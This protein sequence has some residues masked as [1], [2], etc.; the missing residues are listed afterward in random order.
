MYYAFDVIPHG[1]SFKIIDVQ[2]TTGAG[3]HEMRT[4]YGRPEAR[5]RTKRYVA[6]LTE[7]AKGKII[8]Y[9]HP[10]PTAYVIHGMTKEASELYKGNRH[11]KPL[12]HWRRDAAA[13]YRRREKKDENGFNWSRQE[14]RI[15]HQAALDLGADIAFGQQIWQD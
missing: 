9:G 11:W 15:L 6:K 10:S 4:A 3:I 1:D 5:E 14:L 13:H 2:G 7:L 8:V 12:L